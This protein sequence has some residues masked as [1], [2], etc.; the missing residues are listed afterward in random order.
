[1]PTRLCLTSPP[2]KIMTPSS[3]R[4]IFKAVS[5][6]LG[7]LDKIRLRSFIIQSLLCRSPTQCAAVCYRILLHTLHRQVYGRDETQNRLRSK[8]QKQNGQKEDDGGDESKWTLKWQQGDNRQKLMHERHRWE[9]PHE[10]QEWHKRG[11][12]DNDYRPATRGG[13]WRGHK[14]EKSEDWDGREYSRNSPR[15][16]GIRNGKATEDKRKTP[17]DI[18]EIALTESR[19]ALAGTP[20]DPVMWRCGRGWTASFV[21]VMLFVGIVAS[22]TSKG[23]IFID[24]RLWRHPNNY[25]QVNKH[26]QF[27][28]SS[29]PYRAKCESQVCI[30]VWWT[31]RLITYILPSIEW[32]RNSAGRRVVKIFSDY[33]FSTGLQSNYHPGIS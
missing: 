17:S 4:Q 1:M 18:G 2:P 25:G 32:F 10:V 14:R 5:G 21:T 31:L 12:E 9:W 29:I 19:V 28:N 3:C 16:R 23:M 33:R 27:D 6:A 15:A 11:K 26:R 8:Q 13:R 22:I 24:W 30:H 7:A 20:H